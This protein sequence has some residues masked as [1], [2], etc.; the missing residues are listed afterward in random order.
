MHEAMPI[1]TPD[2]L[3]AGNLP[4]G[5]VVL[6]DDDHFYLGGELAGLAAD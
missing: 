5:N 6:Y 2:D 1:F 3:M 4:A